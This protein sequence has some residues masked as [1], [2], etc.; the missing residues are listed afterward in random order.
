M[1]DLGGEKL[2]TCGQTDGREARLV[3]S[4]IPLLLHVYLQRKI[5]RIIAL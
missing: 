5:T 4:H 1:N 3:D 2:T